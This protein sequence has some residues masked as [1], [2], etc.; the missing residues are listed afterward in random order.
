MLSYV[1]YAAYPSSVRLYVYMRVA[2]IVRADKQPGQQSLLS[3]QGSQLPLS[4]EEEVTCR[5][6]Q[7][8]AH[9]FTDMRI[10]NDEGQE[11]PWDGQA[12]GELQVR[13]PHVIRAYF[14]VS[15]IQATEFCLWFSMPTWPLRHHCRPA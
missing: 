2:P 12:A 9:L 7:G 8:R 14:K 15:P 4:K 13:G 11:L 1:I 10:V 6:T 3:L 5:M